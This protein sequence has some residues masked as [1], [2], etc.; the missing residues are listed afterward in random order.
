MWDGW[1]PEVWARGGGCE[2]CLPTTRFFYT[3]NG[4]LNLPMRGKSSSECKCCRCSD[5]VLSHFTVTFHDAECVPSLQIVPVYIDASDV[6]AVAFVSES[7]RLRDEV[8]RQIES[9]LRVRYGRAVPLLVISLGTLF[10]AMLVCGATYCLLL[11]A[12]VAG[13]RVVHGWPKWRHPP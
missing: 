1:V 9:Q 10:C 4:D 5:T 13:A 12:Q 2:S 11:T 8:L 7:L 6:P 3:G